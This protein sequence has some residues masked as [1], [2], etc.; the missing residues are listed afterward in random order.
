MDTVIE[1][2]IVVFTHFTH[3]EHFQVI[4]D[5]QLN[6]IQGKK[7]KTVFLQECLVL[8]VEVVLIFLAHYF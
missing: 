5:M 1:V 6:K 2:N 8:G 4:Q 7:A 3:I